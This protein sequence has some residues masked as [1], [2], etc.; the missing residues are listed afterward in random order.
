MNEEYL[1]MLSPDDLRSVAKETEA[2]RESLSGWGDLSATPQGRF[3]LKELKRTLYNIRLAYSKIPASNDLAPV[4]LAATQGDE[5]RV[6]D[7]ISKLE[8]SSKAKLALDEKVASI[9]SILAMKE[10]ERKSTSTPLV[11]EEAKK[12]IERAQG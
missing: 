12:E 5:Q 9:V 8:D 11:A 6:V 7:L 2:E 4:L 10:K 1:L 3:L